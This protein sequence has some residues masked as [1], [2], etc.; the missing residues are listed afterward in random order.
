M[1]SEDSVSW[2]SYI[3]TL[4]HVTDM[5]SCSKVLVQGES[6]VTILYF[7]TASFELQAHTCKLLRHKL[8]TGSTSYGTC[9]AIEQLLHALDTHREVQD[10]TMHSS[11]TLHHSWLCSRVQQTTPDH[12][13]QHSWVWSVGQQT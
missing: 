11:A 6:F 8:H 9:D 13:Q 2:W 10:F 12:T 1:L 4:K 5:Q 7:G 3:L